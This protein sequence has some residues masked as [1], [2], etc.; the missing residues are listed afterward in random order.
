LEPPEGGIPDATGNDVSRLPDARGDMGVDAPSFMDA[1]D[2]ETESDATDDGVVDQDAPADAELDAG[3]DVGPDV[4]ESGVEAGPEAG[5]DASDGAADAAAEAD[6]GGC[7]DT[8][9]GTLATYDLSSLSGISTSGPATSVATGITAADITRS[10]VLK[11]ESA[12]GAI[13]S[14]NW[15]LGALDTTRYYTFTITPPAKCAMAITSVS[16][17]TGASG[18]GPVSGDVATSADSFTSTSAFTPGTTTNVTLTV[19]GATTAIEV[20][21][22]GYNATG[23]GGTMRIQNTM[24]VSGSLK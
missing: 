10:A 14:S 4:I 12:T 8:I 19:T 3:A 15:S 2:D 20:R 5:L 24:T 9:T 13:N 21:V 11:P 18:T 22:Y 23:T 16:L 6:A 7:P 1:T 17:N